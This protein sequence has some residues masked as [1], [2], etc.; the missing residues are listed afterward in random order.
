LHSRIG[1]DENMIDCKLRIA[2]LK[3]YLLL[4][5]PF[6]VCRCWSIVNPSPGT[7]TAC[8]VLKRPVFCWRAFAKLA[9]RKRKKCY[10]LEI[11]PNFFY[12]RPISIFPSHQ[13]VGLPRNFEVLGNLVRISHTSNGCCMVVPLSLN[14]IIWWRVS[15]F[16]VQHRKMDKLYYSNCDTPS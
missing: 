16:Y 10:T 1:K 9:E 8:T 14:F 15:N 6:K 12:K 5:F 7:V 3:I 4:I 13:R 11:F 2:R